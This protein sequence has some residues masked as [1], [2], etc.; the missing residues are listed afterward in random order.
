MVVIVT[1]V[2]CDRDIARHEN[3]IKVACPNCIKANP[4]GFDAEGKRKA[5]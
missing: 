1:C 2:T 3:K 4:T 5:Q